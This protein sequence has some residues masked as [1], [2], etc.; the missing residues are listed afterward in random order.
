MEAQRQ[1]LSLE[2]IQ[3]RYSLDNEMARFRSLAGD[4]L[5]AGSLEQFRDKHRRNIDK[6]FK[7]EPP[8]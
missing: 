5:N 8:R 3:E 1:G 2:Q 6:I 7:S 4:A